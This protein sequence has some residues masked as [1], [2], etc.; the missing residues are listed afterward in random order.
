MQNREIV[1]HAHP[2]LAEALR[3][4]IEE[5]GRRGWAR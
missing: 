1:R 5:A 2:Q 3:L 4:V